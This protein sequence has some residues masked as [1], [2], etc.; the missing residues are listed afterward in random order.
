MIGY[1][2]WNDDKDR[3]GDKISIT[4]LQIKYVLYFVFIG[5]I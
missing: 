4:L 3:G 2:T 5:G 1:S